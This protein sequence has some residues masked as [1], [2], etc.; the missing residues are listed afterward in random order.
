WQSFNIGVGESTR[1]VQPSSS[2]V[3]WNNINDGNPSQILGN[4]S[5]NGYVVL[6]N[7]NGFFIGGQATITAHGL[8]M[9][10]ARIP[11]PD[12]SVGGPWQFNALP[13]TANIINYGQ[14]G[15]DK[16]GSIFLISEEI[17]NH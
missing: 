7:A 1:F 4:L 9:T 5:A 2:S 10:T 11:M 12:L 8:I 3:V 16:G 17:E 15:T 6:Q 13:P 14:I